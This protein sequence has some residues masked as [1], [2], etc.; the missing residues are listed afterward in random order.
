MNRPTLG[1]IRICMAIVIFGLLVS[2]VTAFPLQTELH[3]LTRFL[4]IADAA[5]PEQ[6]SGL[7][8]WL[9]TVRD[10]LDY[11]AI[12]YPFLAYGTDWLAF[13]H[14][15][16]AIL[17]IGPYRDPVRN[18]WVI[19]FGLISC[20]SVIA[21]ALI[22]GPMRGIPLGHRLIDCSFGILAAIPLGIARLEV[23]RL[24]KEGANV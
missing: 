5:A 21:L 10:A 22:A 18:V 3:W 16:L 2:G 17:F 1:R 6:L 11:N 9:T 12:H 4:G 15:V 13:A 24:I 14:L 20:V 23:G 8:R 19:D 7:Y